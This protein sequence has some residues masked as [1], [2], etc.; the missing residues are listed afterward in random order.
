MIK[1]EDLLAKG[2]TAEQVTELLDMFHNDQNATV[3]EL[4]TQIATLTTERDSA[5]GEAQKYQKGGELYQDPAEFERLRT[6]EQDTL[7]RDANT[8]KT[9][10]LTKL[11]KSANAGDSATKLLIK[12]TDLAKI[13]L[14]DK[15]EI[16]GGADILKQAKADYSDFF[17]DSGEEGAGA[18]H[19]GAEKEV[20]KGFNFN[21]TG[22]RARPDASKK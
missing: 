14:D 22:I 21:F 7:T 13:E 4:R 2:Y 10:A 15:G 8:K 1:R 20:G 9:D 5:R 18:P 17:A 16:K 6:F 12:G 3:A 19:A 11:F